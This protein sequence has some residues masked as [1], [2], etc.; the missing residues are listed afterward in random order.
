VWIVTYFSK[1]EY[2]RRPVYRDIDTQQVYVYQ[3]YAEALKEAVTYYAG[4]VE[5]YSEIIYP[6]KFILGVDNA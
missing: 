5:K 3:T 2:R 6:N 1:A 4:M